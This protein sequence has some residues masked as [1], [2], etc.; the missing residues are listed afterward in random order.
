MKN[1]IAWNPMPGG[2]TYLI[3]RV[4]ETMLPVS[5]EPLTGATQY[6]L[7]VTQ[8]IGGRAYVYRTPER[9]FPEIE[10]EFQEYLGNLDIPYLVII[11]N[12]CGLVDGTIGERFMEEFWYSLLI[13]E[14]PDLAKELFIQ[15]CYWG[16]I[17][18][19]PTD[20]IDGTEEEYSE[21]RRRNAISKMDNGER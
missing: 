1:L 4:D 11:R 12:L 10:D 8:V 7:G 21:E 2:D 3:Y 18:N 9:C 13:K 5:P 20:W 15:P 19:I 14:R 16:L 6:L 17:E